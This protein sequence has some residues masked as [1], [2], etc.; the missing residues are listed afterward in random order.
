MTRGHQQYL[1]LI[2]KPF[3]VLCSCQLEFRVGPA[4][5]TA[6]IRCQPLAERDNL[7]QSHSTLDKVTQC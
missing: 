5:L 6:T 7:G 2:T 3:T 4:Q 1:S